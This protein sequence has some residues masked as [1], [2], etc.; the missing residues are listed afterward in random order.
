M[1]DLLKSGNLQ[2]LGAIFTILGI[3][4]IWLQLRQ[5]SVLS[6]SNFENQLTQEYREIIKEIP[7]LALLDKSLPDFESEDMK[8]VFDDHEKILMNFYRYF[9]L[10]NEQVFLMMKNKISKQTWYEWQQG[11]KSNIR[12]KAFRQAFSLINKTNEKS[13]DELKYFIFC[14]GDIKLEFCDTF[15]SSFHYPRFQKFTDLTMNADLNLINEQIKEGL[16][17]PDKQ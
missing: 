5:A 4:I 8:E 17:L 2:G 11:I 14:D 1:D 16:Y 7:I 9:D 6:R 15:D 12:K 3:V 13:F 10:S